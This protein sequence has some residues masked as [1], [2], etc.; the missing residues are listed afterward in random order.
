MDDFSL[1]GMNHK[2]SQRDRATRI[3]IAIN[4]HPKGMIVDSSSGWP[5]ETGVPDESKSR[6]LFSVSFALGESLGGAPVSTGQ[7][8]GI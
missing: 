3:M 8:A 7:G 1:F 4:I 6:R 5:T 2:I